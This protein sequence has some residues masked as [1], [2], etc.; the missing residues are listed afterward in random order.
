MKILFCIQASA[1][2]AARWINQFADTGWDLHV[3]ENVPPGHGVCPELRCG[4]VHV[5][6]PRNLPRGV[7]GSS[8]LSKSL[9]A[10]LA[11]KCGRTPGPALIA[12]ANADYL[13]RLLGDLRPDVIHLLGLGV[14]WADQSEALMKVRERLG[15]R[16]PAPLVY[17]SWGTDLEI[18]AADPGNRGAVERFL[19]SA[20]YLV[21]ECDRD[22]RLACEMG[23]EGAFL[24]KFPAFGG[25][26]VEDMSRRYVSEIPSRRRL[27]AIKGRDR[28]DGDSIGRAMTLMKAFAL[29]RKELSSY[30]IA[31]LQASPDIAQ[32]AALLHAETGIDISILPRLSYDGVMRMMGGARVFGAITVNDGL[33]SS[34]VEAM[35][36]GALPLHS[37]LEPIR[38]WIE[39]GRN[40]LLA[41][42]EDAEAVAYALRRALT[43]DALVDGAAEINRGLVRSRLDYAGTRERA[44]EMYRGI[45]S[46]SIPEAQRGW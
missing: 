27:V 32:E 16:L 7:S 44:T 31:V 35:A 41:P 22:R 43:D 46:G 2:H 42:P 23:F 38:E 30:R 10:R 3:F 12:R 25:T 15:G 26:H 45:A 13:A 18:F 34:L 39:D 40:G 17:S 6:Y 36:V 14:N 21:T 33:P 28:D 11:L 9:P 37:D 20:D 29:C 1:L 8:V 5:A 19:K 24:G 4:H